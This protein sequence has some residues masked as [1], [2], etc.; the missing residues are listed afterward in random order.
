VFRM[1]RF[2]FTL[3][4]LLVV[5]AIIAILAAIAF[6][7]IARAKD[8][9]YRSSDLNNMNSLRSALQVYRIDQG[10][11]PPA[12]LGYVTLYSTG[13]QIGQVVP[14]HAL[15]SFLYPRRVTSLA[16][17]TPSYERSGPL[18]TTQAVW[19]EQDPRAAGSA[20]L[21]DT[22]GDGALTAADDDACSR[23][24]YGPTV[25]VTRRDP[26]TGLPVPAV[27]YSVSGYDVARTRLATG[28]TRNELRYALF[29]TFWAMGNDV[30]CSPSGTPGN[31][32]DDPRQLGYSEPPENTVVTWNS[33]FRDFQNGA[34]AHTTR[35]IV[36]FLG[37]AAKPFDSNDVAA[38]SWRILP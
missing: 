1:K 10:A 7:V 4:E 6:P 32:L 15:T 23:Q 17:F 36:L 22:N 21:V 25:T 35:D 14:A 16:T 31:A 12:L 29:W 26:I 11:Y 20:P 28:G 34:V 33:Y 5:I 3:I 18:V 19:P 37:G 30:T 24:Q 38:R 13:P 8:S 27:F 2:A 9:A